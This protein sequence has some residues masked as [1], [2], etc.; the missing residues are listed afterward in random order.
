MV[1]PGPAGVV[2]CA[3]RVYVEMPALNVSGPVGTQKV[4]LPVEKRV[5][6]TAPTN[7]PLPPVGAVWNTFNVKLP[8]NGEPADVAGVPDVMKSPK[9][10]PLGVGDTFVL[11][12]PLNVIVMPLLL[13]AL[14]ELALNTPVV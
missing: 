1:Y 7:E 14:L 4:W 11:P 12:S 2:L 6:L 3:N 9:L 13:T 8:E 10:M 5:P